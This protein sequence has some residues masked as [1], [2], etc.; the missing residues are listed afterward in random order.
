MSILIKGMEKPK[1]CYSCPFAHDGWPDEWEMH[2][3]FLDRQVGYFGKKLKVPKDCPLVEVPTP[4]GRLVDADAVLSQYNGNIL[5]AQNDYAEGLR[6]AAED[7][8]TAP[9]IIEAEEGDKNE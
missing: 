9:T 7:I 8:K 3:L 2:C 6:D 4:H 1:D 5:T